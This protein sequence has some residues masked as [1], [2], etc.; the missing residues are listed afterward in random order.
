MVYF[1]RGA[2]EKKFLHRSSREGVLM[3]KN[4]KAILGGFIVVIGV[5]FGFS[6]RS[7]L[8]LILKSISFR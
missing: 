5:G 4:I 8:L 7:D 6:F 3:V 2:L 1:S